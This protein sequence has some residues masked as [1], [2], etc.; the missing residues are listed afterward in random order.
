MSKSVRAQLDSL[1]LLSTANKK[2]RTAV[3][4][5]ADGKLIRAIS[6]IIYNILVGTVDL[7]PNQF[8]KLK[9]YHR[10]LYELSK[11]TNSIT[12]KKAI[13]RQYG[14]FLPTLLPPV[15]LLLSLL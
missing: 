6:E 10:Q 13:L 12:K 7:T 3:I 4:S 15:L 9:R 11:K 14:G 5:Q 2:L 1:R 8:R